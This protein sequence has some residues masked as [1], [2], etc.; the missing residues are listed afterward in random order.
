MTLDQRGY[1]AIAGPAQQITLP[2]SGK[3][4]IFRFCRPLADGN[5]IDDPAL[6][7]PVNAGVPRAANPPLRSQMPNQLLFQRSARLQEQGC[8]KWFRACYPLTLSSFR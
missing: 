4:A 5:G 8:G 1:V 6:R 3:G 2:V 7:V